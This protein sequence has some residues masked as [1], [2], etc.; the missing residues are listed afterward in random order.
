MAKAKQVES[1]ST[2]LMV[3][4]PEEQAYLDSLR[5]AKSAG[6]TG[7]NRLEI[8]TKSRDEDGKKLTIGSWHIT[9]TDMYF[10]GIIKFRPVRSALKLIAYVEDANKN[11]QLRGESIYFQDYRD[12]ILDSTGGVAL[13]RKFG[14][15]FTDEEKE[16]TKK[17]A[18]VYMDVFGFVDIGDGEQRPVMF[19][20]RGGKMFKLSEAFKSLPKGKEFSQY[21][22]DI[23]ALQEVDPTTKKVSDYWTVKVV[24]DMSKTLPITPILA[25]DGEVQEYIKSTN[26]NI[27]QQFR[28]NAGKR[29]EDILVNSV[30]AHTAE[31][32]DE[33][34]PF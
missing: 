6:P 11:W 14:R 28:Q 23:E 24:P 19:R 18:G 26:E 1:E 7:P 29:A 33:E 32:F 25:F 30:T 13:G 5:P 21:A 2:E 31:T 9:N 34:L 4:T 12:E 22:F 10:D 17:L 3:V 27:I 20:T 16:V 15:K 8:N